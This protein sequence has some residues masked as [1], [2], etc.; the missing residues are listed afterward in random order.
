MP[1]LSKGDPVPTRLLR[2][3]GYAAHYRYLH[4]LSADHPAGWIPRQA[5][6]SPYRYSP[7]H[8]LYTDPTRGLIFIVETSH[9]QYD[10]FNVP[11]EIHVY[12]TDDLAT[13]AYMHSLAG[14]HHV[15]TT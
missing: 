1:F 12:E 15:V 5:I 13:D 6:R 2:L 14:G 8:A 9:R 7:T 4:T 11:P 10:V 3:R